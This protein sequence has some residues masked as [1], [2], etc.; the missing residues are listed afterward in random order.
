MW[1]R[2]VACWAGLDDAAWRL[3][4]AAPSDAGGR[5]WSFLDHAA[6][7]VA[8]QALAIDY[9]GRVLR[10]GAWPTDDDY[11]GGDFDRANERLRDEWSALAPSEI[12]RR[13]RTGHD[14]LLSLVQRLE[15]HQIRTDAAW[16]WVYLVLHGHA[17][18][19][20]GVLEPW[21]ERL[22][23]RQAESDPFGA[24][25][26]IGTGDPAVD[27]A[28]F[29]AAKA[30]VFALFEETVMAVSLRDW[31]EDE[32][33]P[34]WSL[35]DHVGN[36]AAWFEQ[37]ADAIDEY[38]RTG[39]WPDGPPEGID[40]WNARAAELGRSHGPEATLE[41]FAAGWARL[42]AAVATLNEEELRSPEGWSWVYECLHGHVRA[43][44][45]MIG[46]WAARASW[47]AG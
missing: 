23:A 13:A 41:R 22:R 33:T 25:P 12:R 2:F 29:H 32:V 20:L 15:L 6:H 19:H 40:A 38:H 11:D 36:M 46:P 17:L 27:R 3:P 5:D 34:G 28:A 9:V 39:T 31:T 26:R 14:G 10:G 45:A 47:P 42:D 35:R 4:G 30:E 24:D 16:G 18:D 8:W 37:G 43:H 44:L 1:D 21:A 7:V